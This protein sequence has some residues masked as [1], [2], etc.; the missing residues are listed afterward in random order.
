MSAWRQIASDLW[1]REIEA[2]F[3]KLACELFMA[4]DS[5]GYLVRIA[6]TGMNPDFQNGVVQSLDP[7]PWAEAEAE[8]DELA[9]LV[10]DNKGALAWSAS[11]PVMLP[12]A[13]WGNMKRS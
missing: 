5:S 9:S 3:G 6:I 4:S 10:I 1:L 8:C 7:L 13:F 2:P 12:T 11:I